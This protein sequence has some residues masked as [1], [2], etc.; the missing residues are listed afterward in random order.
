MLSDSRRGGWRGKRGRFYSYLFTSRVSYECNSF[1]IVCL[2]MC[3]LPL[4][5]P[6][7]QTYAP[8]FQYVG[9]VDGYLGQVLRSGS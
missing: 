2:S 7:R 3:H 9:P 5:W 6:N 8:V 1:D 4:S